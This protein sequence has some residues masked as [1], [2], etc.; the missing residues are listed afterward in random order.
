MNG[1]FLTCRTGRLHVLWAALTLFSANS[2]GAQQIDFKLQK[3][4]NHMTQA[5]HTAAKRAAKNRKF[6]NIVACADPGNMP[7]SN[8][9]E[10]GFQNK[11]MKVVAKH[12][13]TTASFFW[14]PFLER[15]LTRETF[16]NK[17]CRVLVGM[18]ADSERLLT[19]VPI[20]RSTYVFAY[21][22]DS[23]IRI[24]DLD[25]P[26][27]KRR[28]VGVYQHSGL[29]E[30]LRRHGIQD[31]L[32]IHVLSYDA[33]LKTEKQPWRQVQEVIDGKLD[34]AG[35]WGPFAGFLKTMNGE[36]ITLQ[37]ANIM[38]DETPLEFSL[39]I[40]MQKS[41]AVLKYAMDNALEKAKDE[42]EQ[43]LREYGVPLVECSKCI[44]PGDLPSHGSYY[45]R[46]LQD[47]RKRY[48]EPLD[49]KR[50]EL[51]K[52]A[53][54]DQIVTR[55]RLEGWIKE[56]ADL[57]QE[58]E[59]AILA[60]DGERVRFLAEKGANL[61]KLDKQGAAPLHT[62]AKDRDSDMIKLLLELG[63]DVHRKDKDGWTP[64]F[65]AV[66]RNH[67]PSIEHLIKTG[68]DL[69]MK[70]GH[71]VTPLGLAISERN[72]FAAR[73]LL[74][75]GASVD[76]TIGKEEVTPLMLV[77]TQQKSFSRTGRIN[78]GVDPIE[79][80]SELV[81]RGADVNAVSKKGIT[82]LMVAAGHDT[83]AMIAFLFKN[84][85]KLDAVSGDGKTALDIAQEA[86]NDSAIKSLELFKNLAKS[87]PE[88]T[89]KDDSG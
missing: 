3:D 88:R 56:G 18:P 50:V 12:M 77:A 20:Y 40:G 69:E 53:T 33:D 37:P 30:A 86:L 1:M 61:N 27:L 89:G 67:V 73:A 6:P 82:A 28:R 14:R 9:R 16:A 2:A 22:S 64:L 71:G 13:G 63:A 81:E 43:I 17:E 83:P 10:E 76:T 39:A 36:P 41:E 31:E 15:G 55:K 42:I 78:Q 60:S 54:P 32:A 21:R 25:D 5:E 58:V 26:V 29:R 7:L 46:F 24:K 59:N 19:T 48:V 84:G 35:V 62:A 52:A 38:E 85:A 65:H 80:A 47:A 11:I 34:I 8:H 45:K 74:A 49:R 4:F 23:A 44:V 87:K 75:G 72:F 68:A 51:S 70:N 79:I 57:S 66:F